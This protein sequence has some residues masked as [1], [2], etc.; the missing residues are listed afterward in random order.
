MDER[1]RLM[2]VDEPAFR[3][4]EAA[5]A[6]SR[7]LLGD[8]MLAAYL[9]GSA[10]T[11]GLRPHS[12]VDLLIVVKCRLPEETRDAL[13]SE[14]LRVSAASGEANGRPLEVTLVVQSDVK[15]WRYPPRCEFQFGEWLRPD[16]EAGAIPQ[17]GT[18][19]DLAIL[20]TTL[21]QHSQTLYGPAAVEMFDPVPHGDLLEAV[22]DM[23]PHLVAGWSDDVTNALL[24]LS[25]MWATAV[26]GEIMAKHAAAAWAIERLPDPHGRVLLLASD[27]YIGGPRPDWSAM[28]DKVL[29]V[30]LDL[31]RAIEAALA[32]RR[33]DDRVPSRETIIYSSR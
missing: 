5:L 28:T 30:V 10:V 24:T 23:L 27:D 13:T 12:D 14:L 8:A 17:P 25:R 11:D 19:P 26:T 3:Q 9:Y 21:R 31:Q 33:L 29:P 16:L 15:P 18:D 20:L 22:T 32:D 2:A 7:H 4:L 1:S 6:A